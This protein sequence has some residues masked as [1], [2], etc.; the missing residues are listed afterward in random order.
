MG[1]TFIRQRSLFALAMGALMAITLRCRRPGGKGRE[2]PQ[3]AADSRKDRGV[4]KG[5][6]GPHAVH[7][8]HADRAQDRRQLQGHHKD[9]DTLSTKEYWGEVQIADGKGGELKIPMQLGRA[10]TTGLRDEIALS[11]RSGSTSRKVR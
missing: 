6:R 4:E 9:R 2:G 5:G 8:R 3:G 7:G 10:A 11:F 1:L